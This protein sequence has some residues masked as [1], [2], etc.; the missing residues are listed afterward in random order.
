LVQK[1]QAIKKKIGYDFHPTD[2]IFTDE[3]LAKLV[4][5]ALAAGFLGALLGAGMCIVLTPM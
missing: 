5:A 1:E 4:L 2:F 3:K